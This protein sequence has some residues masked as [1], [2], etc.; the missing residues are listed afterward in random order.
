MKKFFKKIWWSYIWW[1]FYS[2]RT[3]WGVQWY[4]STPTSNKWG[5]SCCISD[6]V[7]F[8]K[9]SAEKYWESIKDRV[10][11]DQVACL[12]LIEKGNYKKELEVV[13]Y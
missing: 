3:T 6:K 12:W 5:L 4:W 8:R 9:K 10:T 11:E 1:Y 2:R 7:F 13:N